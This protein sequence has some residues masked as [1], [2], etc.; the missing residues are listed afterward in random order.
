MIVRYLLVEKMVMS[1]LNK[2]QSSYRGILLVCLSQLCMLVKLIYK[3]LYTQ[4]VCHP[5]FVCL[6]QSSDSGLCH[7][8][9]IEVSNKLPTSALVLALSSLS[10]IMCMTVH[11]GAIMCCAGKNFL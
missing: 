3:L 9:L 4:S 8:F 1:F 7:V 6:F 5:I 11:P 10:F 2:P